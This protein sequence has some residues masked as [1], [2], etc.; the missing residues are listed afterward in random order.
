MKFFGEKLVIKLWETI[1]EKGIGSIFKPWQMRREGQATIELKRNELLTIAQA[2]HDA[3]KIKR[4]EIKTLAIDGTLLLIENK[5]NANRASDEFGSQLTHLQVNVS[6]SIIAEAVR[7]ESNVVRAILHAEQI[8][9]AD[10]QSAPEKSIDDDWLY[11]WRDNVSEISSEDLR[12]IWGKV[13]AG[14]I[15]SPGS[16]S[17]RTLEF[18]KNLNKQEAEAVAKLSRFVIADFIFRDKSGLLEKEGITVDFLLKMQEM[19]VI[20]GVVSVG[21]T[22]NWKSEEPDRFVQALSSNSM[23]LVVQNPDPLKTISIPAYSLTT[24]GWEVLRLGEFEPHIE[25]LKMV[26]EHLKLQGF[27]VTLAKYSQLNTNDIQWF[28]GQNL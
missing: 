2:E 18:L 13:L 17:L 24:I 7:K 5:I 22:K 11:R 4:G 23:V 16:Y 1:T 28:E 27:S 26:G 15:K 25:Y 12:S 3:E 19:G 14:E 8:L 21:M 6:N 10:N 20:S 9:E